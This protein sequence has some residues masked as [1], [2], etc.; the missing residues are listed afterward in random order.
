[1]HYRNILYSMYHILCGSVFSTNLHLDS[2]PDR[3]QKGRFKGYRNAAGGWIRHATHLPTPVLRKPWAHHGERSS[4]ASEKHQ[5][6]SRGSGMLVGDQRWAV[7]LN[8]RSQSVM[9]PR[10]W[11]KAGVV[12]TPLESL[13]PTLSKIW[14]ENLALGPMAF[15]CKLLMVR[16]TDRQKIQPMK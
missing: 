4:K 11:S 14:K 7:A 6:C 12:N 16:N 15:K 1:M 9:V 2:N 8:P 10:L 5:W 3:R 13:P